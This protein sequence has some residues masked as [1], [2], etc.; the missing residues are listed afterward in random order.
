MLCVSERKMDRVK[1]KF[2]PQGLELTLNRQPAK[3]C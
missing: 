3:S 1:K 2:S